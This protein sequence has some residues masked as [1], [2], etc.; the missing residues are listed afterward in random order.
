MHSGEETHDSRM[1]GDGAKHGSG[2][3]RLQGCKGEGSKDVQGS[4]RKRGKKEPQEDY[5]IGR[6]M[7]P[8]RGKK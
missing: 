3:G 6:K 1:G 4:E 7:E 5:W 8:S 2:S